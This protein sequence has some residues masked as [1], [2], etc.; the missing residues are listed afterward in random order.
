MTYQGDHQRTLA[1][2]LRNVVLLLDRGLIDEGFAWEVLARMVRV[3]R[4][5]Y[6]KTWCA[7]PLSELTPLEAVHHQIGYDPKPLE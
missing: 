7:R 2:R 3:R 6:R 5:I 1:D 4:Q